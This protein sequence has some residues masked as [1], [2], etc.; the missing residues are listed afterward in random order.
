[1]ALSVNSPFESKRPNGSDA[2][3]HAAMKQKFD[4]EKAAAEAAAAGN[5]VLLAKIGGIT[6]H[7]GAIEELEVLLSQALQEKS[8]SQNKT[9][10][11]A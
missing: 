9:I 4:E 2:A 11:I 6:P 8:Q 5:P 3:Q 7:K 10:A 1:M